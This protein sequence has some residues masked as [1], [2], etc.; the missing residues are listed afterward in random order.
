MS[1]ELVPDNSTYHN[2]NTFARQ[3]RLHT[4]ATNT[5]VESYDAKVITHHRAP[6]LYEMVFGTKTLPKM[7]KTKLRLA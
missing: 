7:R 1:L 4:N 3:S 2:T 5:A 6:D